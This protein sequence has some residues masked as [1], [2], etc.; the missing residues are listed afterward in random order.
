MKKNIKILLSSATISSAII[1]AP[2]IW[3]LNTNEPKNNHK[4]LIHEYTSIH[5]MEKRFAKNS[6]PLTIKWHKIS[7]VMVNGESLITIQIETKVHQDGAILQYKNGKDWKNVDSNGLISKLKMSSI[8]FKWVNDSKHKSRRFYDNNLKAK[9]KNFKN[10]I[11]AAPIGANAGDKVTQANI[12]KRNGITLNGDPVP[13]PGQKE[14]INKEFYNRKLFG[15]DD[16]NNPDDNVF[17]RIDKKNQDNITIEKDSLINSNS[18]VFE[19]EF[20]GIQSKIAR[21]SIKDLQEIVSSKKGGTYSKHKG[22]A[23]ISFDQKTNLF[24]Y[25]IIFEGQKPINVDLGIDYEMKNIIVNSKSMSADGKKT[26]QIIIGPILKFSQDKSDGNKLNL[27]ISFW[28]GNY[29]GYEDFAFFK[30]LKIYQ[31]KWTK[32]QIAARDANFAARYNDVIGDVYDKNE[33]WL[34]DYKGFNEIKTSTVIN[35][36]KKTIKSDE[37]KKQIEKNLS[38]KDNITF[39]LKNY[40]NDELI[41]TNEVLG[42]DSNVI[43]VLPNQ[44]LHNGSNKIKLKTVGATFDNSKKD[45]VTNNLFENGKNSI[46]IDINIK[47][48]FYSIISLSKIKE[49]IFHENSSEFEINNKTLGINS[50]GFK[51]LAGTQVKEGINK[52][53]LIA[54]PGFMFPDHKLEK[55]ITLK[56]IKGGSKEVQKEIEY[57]KNKMKDAKVIDQKLLYLQEIVKEINNADNINKKLDLIK[58]WSGIELPPKKGGTKIT[59]VVAST[60]NVDSEKQKIILKFSTHS[61][62]IEEEFSNN[63]FSSSLEGESSPHIADKIQKL[64]KTTWE[65]SIKDLKIIKENQSYRLLSDI[66]TTITDLY[67]FSKFFNLDLSSKLK[68]S[69]LKDVSA[70]AD[71]Q[72][73]LKIQGFL[74]TPF[75]KK[76][77]DKKFELSIKGGKPDDDIEYKSEIFNELQKKDVS[78]IQNQISSELIKLENKINDKIDIKTI[79]NIHLLKEKLGIDLNLNLKASIIE[80]VKLFKNKE[81]DLILDT[82]IYTRKAYKSSLEIKNVIQFHELKQDSSLKKIGAIGILTIVLSSL[83][84]I[85]IIILAIYLIKRNDEYTYS[86]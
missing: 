71:D 46:V 63:V 35:F 29:N 60:E 47:D 26:K 62:K 1:A 33:V 49:T 44:K 8:E 20:Y 9:F 65:E 61:E 51:V 18:L 38:D 27:N 30:Q 76:P 36:S 69:F 48:R 12:D 77:T 32:E 2:I 64:D 50:K 73:N 74:Y 19:F 80:K 28:T 57:L 79:T 41:A 75:A 67:S 16:D 7:E 83:S 43:S 4:S 84:M 55:T 86:Q 56:V 31:N 37:I 78:K 10:N 82:Y 6:L 13:K 22:K 25:R 81:G 14:M 40:A 23:I 17:H 42:I 34:R 58:K 68:G 52:V 85:G 66:A 45:F 3:K 53:K 72:G 21:P 70:E 11:T 59:D 54:E 39:L 5:D 15:I 24:N